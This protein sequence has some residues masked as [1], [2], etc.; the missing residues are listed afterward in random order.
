MARTTRKPTYAT[1]RER[2]IVKKLQTLAN[3]GPAIADDLL[4]LGMTEPADLAT[5]DAEEL[6][7]E[8]CA[9]DGRRHD[10]CVLDTFMAAVDEARGNPPQPWWAYTP[11]RKARQAS[12]ATSDTP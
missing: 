2:E 10:P 8:L 11:V 12:R 5:R 6:Y 7:E 1:A 4:R 9:L 3:I